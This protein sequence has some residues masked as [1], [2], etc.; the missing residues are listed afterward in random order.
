MSGENLEG[1]KKVGFDTDKYLE[2]QT[3]AIKER[4]AKFKKLYLEFG[5]KIYN[6]FHAA[7]A[8]HGYRASAKM[9][10]LKQL[11]DIEILYCVSAKD[12]EKG[13]VRGDTGLSYDN[14]TLKEIHDIADFGLKINNV[15]ITR[16]QNEPSIEKFKNRLEN[17]GLKVC[18]HKEIAGYPHNIDNVLKG[19]E[20]QPLVEISKKLTI[21]T[22]AGGNSGKM[23]TCLSQVYNERRQGDK[24]G[25][26]K[27]ETFPIWNLDLNHPINDAYEAATADLLDVNM[28]DPFHEKAYGVKAVNYNRDI[29]NFDI[30]IS[31]MERITGEKDPFGYKSPT[32]MG[33]NTAA[34]GIVDDEACRESAKQEIIRRYFRYQKEKKQGIETQGTLDRMAEIMEKAGVREED[35]M[36]VQ[37]ARQAAQEAEKDEKKGNKGIF[38]GAAL[39]LPDGK[40]ITGKNSPLLH[41]ESAVILN[42][43]KILAKIPDE[44]PLLPQSVLEDIGKLKIEILGGRT[45]SLNL[46]EALIALAV[47][48]S[49][50]PTAN[51]CIGM[52]EKLRGCELH[53][54]HMP[55]TGDDAGLRKLGL[56]VTTDGEANVKL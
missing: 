51:A 4:V 26:A 31:I 12:I 48:T 23:A 5:G 27:F 11:G 28:I 15:V 24:T 21:V 10:L 19:Y 2:A 50:N 25:Y 29:E 20:G 32:D 34:V 17:A 18:I 35:R 44:V 56:N 13:K 45:E 47:S 39:E 8:I 38:C 37:P 14:Q 9:D 54:T 41:A 46:E 22:G 52:L 49:T 40:I 33:V 16:Y 7:R 1:A 3:K 6:D 43:I 30:L 53:T 36:V 42:A 55:S